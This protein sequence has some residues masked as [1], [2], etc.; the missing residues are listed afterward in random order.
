MYELFKSMP[1]WLYDS[2]GPLGF[3][4]R[5]SVTMIFFANL[6]FTILLNPNKL[7]WPHQNARLAPLDVAVSDAVDDDVGQRLPRQQLRRA[8]RLLRPFGRSLRVQ[9]SMID[10]LDFAWVDVWSFDHSNIWGQPKKSQ[11]FIRDGLEWL[12]WKNSQ[13][14]SDK[15]PWWQWVN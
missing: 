14:A 11:G 8:V 13:L 12:F 3:C 1:T 6:T 5:L 2:S 9:V 10:W 7:K 15:K 4:H